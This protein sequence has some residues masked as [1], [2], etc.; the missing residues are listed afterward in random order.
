MALIELTGTLEVGNPTEAQASW[1]AVGRTPGDLF[2]AITR[3]FSV[4]ITGLDQTIEV[5]LGDTQ[6]EGDYAGKPWFDNGSIPRIGIPTGTEYTFIYAYPPNVPFLWIK[7]AETKPSYLRVLSPTELS[8]Y[9]LTNPEGG[10]Y[11]YV[12]L[13]TSS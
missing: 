7:G 8:N 13:E 6:P 10:L 2:A 11:F 12:I 3:V 9:G 4:R 1:D 5:Y